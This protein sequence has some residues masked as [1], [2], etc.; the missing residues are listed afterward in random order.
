MTAPTSTN[1][2]T[3]VDARDLYKTA[4][5]MQTDTFFVLDITCGRA[6]HWNRAFR[7]ISGYSDEEIAQLKAPDSYYSPEELER[8]NAA[9]SRIIAGESATLEISLITKDGRHIPTEYQASPIPDDTGVIK[10][11]IS[12][13]RDVTDRRRIETSTRESE[14]LFR[15]LIENI[16]S[17]AW[18]TAQNGR[19]SYI[20]PNVSK[21]YG[22]TPEEILAAG[23]AL[24]MERI[25][26]DDRETV[27]NA[28]AALFSLR[29]PF[30]V[31]YRLLHRDG[32]WIWLHDRATIL[33]EEDGVPFAI[34]VFSDITERK[35]AEEEKAR[36][37]E[38]LRQSEKLEAVGQLAG[39]VAHDFNNQLAGV[40]GYAELLRELVR[41]NPTALNFVNRIIHA[42]ERSADLTAKLLTFARKGTVEEMQV[43]IHQIVH[44]VISI[45][46]HSADKKISI[47]H[48]LHATGLH[49]RGELSQLQNVLLNLGI[50]ACQAMPGGGDFAVSHR[51]GDTEGYRL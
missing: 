45:L 32:R 42:S 38:H 35:L 15:V 41:D 11:L 26:P 50:N 8:A 33:E 47:Q 4:L 39:G 36:L 25:H 28:F 49:T 16:P 13:G 2:R 14:R 3:A 48:R 7:E 37:E 6:V 5:D 40:L 1:A 34:G 31:E 43:D 21:I 10:Y 18:I 9:I 22:Y 29:C 17:V 27:R 30:D 51:C 44:E 12:V 46:E 24:W 23:D 20:S 19:T